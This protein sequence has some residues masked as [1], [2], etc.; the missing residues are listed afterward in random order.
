M[1]T[2]PTSYPVKDAL[3]VS[4]DAVTKLGYAANGTGSVISYQRTDTTS[5]TAI[6]QTYTDSNGDAVTKYVFKNG[7]GAEINPGDYTNDISKILELFKTGEGKKNTY[8]TDTPQTDSAVV[9]KEYEL[10][11]LREMSLF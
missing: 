11:L 7:A 10:T 9:P 1:K 8:V 6:M 4:E 5:V 2:K 3:V